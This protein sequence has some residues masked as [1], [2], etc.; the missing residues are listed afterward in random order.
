MTDEQITN[1]IKI[2]CAADSEPVLTSEE[3]SYLLD[4][5]KTTGANFAFKEGWEI[6]AGKCASN[7]KF[8]D[9]GQS[10][11]KESIQ[12]HCLEM[13]KLYS[14]MPDVSSSSALSN[15]TSSELESTSLNNLVNASNFDPDSED[16]D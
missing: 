4:V 10:F 11:D 1:L 14:K 12:K 7:Y 9:N 15:K 6:K 8:S 5:Y 13:V 16:L 2:K 3:L